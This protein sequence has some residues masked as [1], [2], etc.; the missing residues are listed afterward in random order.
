MNIF[1]LRTST[2]LG[3]TVVAAGLLGIAGCSSSST[4]TPSASPSAAPKVLT[5][6]QIVFGEVLKHSFQPGGTGAMQTER[7]SLSLIHI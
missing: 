7:L 5:A 6:R 1:S 2:W 4:T 3:A